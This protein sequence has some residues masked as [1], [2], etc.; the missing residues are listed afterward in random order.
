M[1]IEII[2]MHPAPRIFTSFW[3]PSAPVMKVKDWYN[4]LYLNNSFN[5]MLLVIV[6][7]LVLS[8]RSD[9]CLSLDKAYLH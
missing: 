1:H 5:R 8:E 4:V 9:E 3:T 7:F 2:V 6:L